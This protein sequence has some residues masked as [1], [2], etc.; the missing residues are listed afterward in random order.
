MTRGSFEGKKDAGSEA[1][2]WFF[3][4]STNKE[5]MCIDCQVDAQVGNG[6]NVSER[7]L[8]HWRAQWVDES[9]GL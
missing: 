9:D 7:R 5:A 2:A 3:E 4:G 1:G 6:T 8:D